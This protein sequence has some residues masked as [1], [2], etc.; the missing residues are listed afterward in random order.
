MKK[1]CLLLS[2]SIIYSLYPIQAQQGLKADYYNGTDLLREDWVMSRIDP[3]ID[4]DWQMGTSPANGIS[5]NVYSVRWTGRLQAPVSGTYTFSAKV[6]DGIRVWVGNLLILD[7]WGLHDSED[8]SGTIA[9]DAGKKY[10]IRVEYFNGLR[11]GEIHLLWEI[12]DDK[13]KNSG[14]NY[15]IISSQYFSQTSVIQEVIPSTK[16]PIVTTKPP[17]LVKKPIIQ[18]KN[19]PSRL[20]R[21]VPSVNL[22]TATKY[23]PKHVLFVKSKPTM[24]PESFEELDNL[25][26]MLKRFPN[27]KV[28][29]EGHTDNVGDSALNLKL[30]EE[31]ASAVVDY[32]IKKGIQSD[33]LTGDMRPLTTENTAEGHA[34]NR[35]VEF[36]IK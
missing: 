28:V 36:I 2:L 7:A 21:D 12:P 32:L 30:S 23:V 34:E 10:N 18:S 11:E 9:L 29:V 27:K 20:S 13:A 24:L 33:R 26:L 6:D 14:H 5:P 15:Q 19:T 4:F 1:L 16:K 25:V 3:Q 31:R 17:V 22:D 8:F 35:R